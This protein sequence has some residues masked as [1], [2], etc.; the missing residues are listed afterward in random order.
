MCSA[1]QLEVHFTFATAQKKTLHER[2]CFLAVNKERTCLCIRRH[3]WVRYEWICFIDSATPHIRLTFH[4]KETLYC[5]DG[6]K[7]HPSTW[8]AVCPCFFV[9]LSQ[10]VFYIYVERKVHALGFNFPKRFW[11]LLHHSCLACVLLFS[12]GQGHQGILSMLKGT[13]WGNCKF[14]EHF[15]GTKG[16]D[17]GAWRQPSSLPLWS[18]RPERC[19][20]KPQY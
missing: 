10:F 8:N 20:V 2:F 9:M 15:K 5:E 14:L 18:I 17:Q 3:E 6:F 16:N 19:F 11:Y 12:K 1:L 4:F 13:R 7:L